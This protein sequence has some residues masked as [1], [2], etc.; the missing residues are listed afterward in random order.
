MSFAFV[1]SVDNR[2]TTKE[3]AGTEPKTEFIRISYCFVSANDVQLNHFISYS[4]YT[5]TLR[6]T[7]N[8]HTNNQKTEKVHIVKQSVAILHVHGGMSF[9]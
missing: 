7:I 1:V 4:K 3:A 6:V 5:I 2:W 9:H 8:A